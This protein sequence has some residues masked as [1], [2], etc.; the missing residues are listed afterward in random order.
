ME[1]SGNAFCVAERLRALKC[2]VVILCSHRAGKVG[3]NYC[4]TDRVDAIKIARI[5]L[6]ALSP[7]VW[8]PDAKTRERRE[9]F[10]AYQA[11]GKEGTRLKQQIKS[12]L[13]EHCVRLEKGFRLSRPSVIRR[14][15]QRRNWT[16]AQQ[17]LLQQLHAGLVGA[18]ARRQ[19]LRH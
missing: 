16:P 14:L 9:V 17:M 13:N 15:L 2:K 12:M 11:V 7:V 3:K 8:Q 5:Y 4:A 19:Q 18:R 6:S 1:A 10:S